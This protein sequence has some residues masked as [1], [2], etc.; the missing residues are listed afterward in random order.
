MQSASFSALAVA[1]GAGAAAALACA[2]VS[3]TAAAAAAAQPPVVLG[4]AAAGAAA[5]STSRGRVH[6]VG[7]PSDPSAAASSV[8]SPAAERAKL[9]TIRDQ[10]LSASALAAAAEDYVEVTAERLDVGDIVAR[11]V[12]PGAGGIALFIGTTRD[13]FNGK[14]VL[15]LECHLWDIRGPI[16]TLHWLEIFHVLWSSWAP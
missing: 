4:A 13:N 6:I 1:A 2:R 3:T 15:Q 16:G 9:A 11:V 8:E 10:P 5:A 12:D 14:V 7:V